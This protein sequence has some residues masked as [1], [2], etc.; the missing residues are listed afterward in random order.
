MEITDNL[1]ASIDSNFISCGLLLDLSKAFDTVNYQ[2]MSEKLCKYGVRGK[3]RDWFASSPR[4]QE[5]CSNLRRKIKFIRDDLG[6]LLFLIYIDDIANLSNKL[7]F[8]LFADDASIF[9]I[10]DDINDI[11][12]VMNYEMTKFLNY[13]SI[14]KLSVDMKKTN[15][16]L[17]T[18]PLKNVTHKYFKFWAKDLHVPWCLYRPTLEFTHVKSKMSKNIGILYKSRHYYVSIHVLKQLKH[19]LIYPYLNYAV[20]VWGNSYP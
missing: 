17:I 4:L 18:S 20:V 13:C 15:F 19:T 5:I 1:K 16:M 10:S 6:P 7:S 2:I 14:N 12:S 3:P 9:Y 8:R 11:E